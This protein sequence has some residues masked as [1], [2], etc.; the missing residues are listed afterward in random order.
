MTRATGIAER[1][2]VFF[3]G[4]SQESNTEIVDYLQHAI[5]Y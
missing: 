2:E 4:K 5:A 1:T 3:I